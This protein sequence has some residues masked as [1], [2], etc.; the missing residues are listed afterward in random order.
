MDSY[1][2]GFQNQEKD[3]EIKGA[4]NS[5]NYTFRMHDPRVGRFFA[6]DPLASKYPWNSTYAF[7][8]NRVIDGAELEGLEYKNMI[9]LGQVN[10]FKSIGQI[11]NSFDF[12]G[13]GKGTDYVTVTTS[14]EQVNQTK[15]KDKKSGKIFY[16]TNYKLVSVTTTD[17][18]VDRDGKVISAIESTIHY[19]TT[20]PAPGE[21][22]VPKTTTIKG[23]EISGIENVV[24]PAQEYTDFVQKSKTTGNKLS[25]VQ[26]QA[27]GNDDLNSGVTHASTIYSVA[28][29][30]EYAAVGAKLIS[31]SR[32]G[33][34]AGVLLGVAGSVASEA[35]REDDP[36]KITLHQ[37]INLV[38]K[39]E[40][41]SNKK[42]WIWKM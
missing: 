7:S 16:H 13:G 8:E 28:S 23:E 27:N 9:N 25:P 31:K 33:G 1:R 36:T 34:L 26:E 14:K 18:Q 21:T 20:Y 6:V 39:K 40:F 12:T 32:L 42:E 22:S 2:Y 4:G 38:S 37:N 15:F 24:K 29:L 11:D 19:L 41:V 3:D 5:V 30:I 35:A 10:L 17:I